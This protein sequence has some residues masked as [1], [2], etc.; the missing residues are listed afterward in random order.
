MLGKNKEREIERERVYGSLFP[1]EGS[2][3]DEDWGVVVGGYVCGISHRL[4]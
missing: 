1:S 3:G 4:E 2:G